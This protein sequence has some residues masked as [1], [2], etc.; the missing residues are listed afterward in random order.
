MFLLLHRVKYR[1]KVISGNIQA[2]NA[3]VHKWTYLSGS[4]LTIFVDALFMQQ[5]AETQQLNKKLTAFYYN[6]V[7]IIMLCI[8]KL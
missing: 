2:Q 1:K 5:H 4:E 8:F 7:L 3:R 6:N